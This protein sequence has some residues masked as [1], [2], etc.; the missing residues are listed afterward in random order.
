MNLDFRKALVCI[1][2]AKRFR[3]KRGT[4]LS[5][6][7]IKLSRSPDPGHRC[8]HHG[9]N[10]DNSTTP[11][12]Q[13]CNVTKVIAKVRKRCQGRRECW[14]SLNERRLGNTCVREMKFL[15]VNFTCEPSKCSSKSTNNMLDFHCSDSVM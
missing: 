3:C 1:P 12:D 4:T 9:R 11:N 15:E 13:H 2:G 5:F 8:R 10:E 14:I 6:V 7:N